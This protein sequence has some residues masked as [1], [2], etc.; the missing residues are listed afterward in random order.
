MQAYEEALKE[1]GC[2]SAMILLTHDDLADRQ[3]YLKCPSYPENAN[4]YVRCPYH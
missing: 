3:R 4:G 1:H 2:G